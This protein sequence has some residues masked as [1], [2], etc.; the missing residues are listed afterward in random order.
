ME[1]VFCVKKRSYTRHEPVLFTVVNDLRLTRAMSRRCATARRHRRAILLIDA[2]KY[3]FQPR[4]VLVDVGARGF[5][6][7]RAVESSKSSYGV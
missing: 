3:A 4:A 5:P 1:S 2:I 7:H 6:R